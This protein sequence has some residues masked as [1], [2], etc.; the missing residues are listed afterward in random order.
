MR[1]A[2]R[3]RRDQPVGVQPGDAVDPRHLDRLRPRTAPAG[4]TAAAARASS[5]RC[6]AAPRAAGCGRRRRRSAA[7]AAAV[8]AADVGEVGLRALAGAPGRHRAAARRRGPPASTSAAAARLATAGDREPFDQRRLPRPLAR[9]DQA[10]E[11]RAA[12]ALGDRQRARRV[13]QLA[14]ER[15]LA[16]HG[17]AQR[18]RR[19]SGR[20]PRARR[21]RARRRSRARP[22]AGTP[23]PG[24]R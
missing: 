16:E 8:L 3:A 17:V 22:C 15:Q 20:S 11:A 2:E 18:V 23:G 13:A 14:A 21:A 12:R 7:R 5:C 6:R 19:R 10:R 24:W 4:S 1:R 9:H